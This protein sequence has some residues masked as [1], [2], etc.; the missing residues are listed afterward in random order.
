MHRDIR[1]NIAERNYFQL[2]VGPREPAIAEQVV[3]DRVHARGRPQD[4]A[5]VILALRA[6]RVGGIVHHRLGK[7]PHELQWCAEIV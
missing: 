4:S 2:D 7:A 5:Q 3:N 6:E 1:H